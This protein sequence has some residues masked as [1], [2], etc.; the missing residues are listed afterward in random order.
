MP[1]SGNNHRSSYERFQGAA[2]HEDE[3]V[4]LPV[5]VP[6]EELQSLTGGDSSML[7]LLQE[8]PSVLLTVT[9][10][11]WQGGSPGDAWLHMTAAQVW[12]IS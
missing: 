11:L 6:A 3:P 8:Q 5:S 12:L 7:E 2:A 4:L 1:G 9:R 10:F